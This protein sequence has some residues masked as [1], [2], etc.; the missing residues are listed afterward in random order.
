MDLKHQK[1]ELNENMSED[2]LIRNLKAIS[3][4]LQTTPQ[5]EETQEYIPLSMQ[6][7]E[8]YFLSHP[9]RDVQLLVACCIADIMRIYA[10][11]APYKDQDLI[12]TIFMFLIN[13]LDGISNPRHKSFSRYFYL[14]EILA[15]TKSFT[16]CFE[17]EDNQEVFI[18]LFK[19]IFKICSINEPNAKVKSFMLDI[20]SPLVCEADNISNELLD[21]IFKHIIEPEKS[22]N[23]NAYELCKQLISKTSEAL[24]IY[25]KNFLSSELVQSS[26]ESRAYE[27]T[28]TT[29]KIFEVIHELYKIAPKS[30][31]LVLPTLE[32]K[33]QS[34]EETSRMRALE[35][36]I[37]IL[38]EEFVVEFPMLWQQFKQRF[39]D[40]APSIRR[41]CVAASKIFLNDETKYRDEIIEQLSTRKRDS[42][43]MVRFE[44]VA[45][46]VD[47]ARK[48]W[49]LVVETSLF[50]VLKERVMDMKFFV[51]KEALQGFSIIY[52]AFVTEAV[53]SDSNLRDDENI[54]AMMTTIKNKILHGYY[55]KTIEDKMLIERLLI[56][57]LVPYNLE[58]NIRMRVL[59]ELLCD[60]D[61]H[62]MKAFIELQ[63]QQ[64]KLRMIVS[65]W[66]KCHKKIE[67]NKNE[68]TTRAYAIASQL[69]DQNKSKEQLIKLSG[70]MQKD[71]EVLQHIEAILSKD[72]SCKKC[73]QKMQ[74]LLKKMGN[75]VATNIYYNTIKNMLNRIASVTVDDESIE[76]LLEIIENK[77][78]GKEIFPLTIL[79]Q[80][81]ATHF[82]N[83]NVLN[84][85]LAL[86][87][88]DTNEIGYKE[89][90][91]KAFTNLSLHKSI[92]DTFPQLS[93]E[94][95]EICRQIATKGTPKQC[96]QAVT[97]MCTNTQNKFDSSEFEI[98]KEIVNSF[99][100]SINI[101]NEYCRTAIVAM[102]VICEVN[103]EYFKKEI[104]KVIGRNI[105][106]GL[107]LNA[108][109][110]QSIVNNSNSPISWIE[111]ELLPENIKC[112][113]AA[114]KLTVHWLIGLKDDIVSAQKTMKIMD[115]LIVTNGNIQEKIVPNKYESSWIKLTAAKSILKLSEHKVLRQSVSA[116]QFLNLSKVMLDES[117]QL[118]GHFVKRLYKGLNKGSNENCLP[119][120]FLGLYVFEG[121]ESD[122]HLLDLT[123]RNFN[124]IINI[125]SKLLKVN[126]KDN[127]N[128][129]NME[130]NYLPIYAIALLTHSSILNESDDLLE[131]RKIEKCLKFIIDPLIDSLESTNNINCIKQLIHKIK[132]SKNK[133]NPENENI[134]VKMWTIT[135]I[136]EKIM[137]Y[138]S[139]VSKTLSDTNEVNI[140]L[141]E[142]YFVMQSSDFCNDK[143]YLTKEFMDNS[144]NSNFSTNVSR[145][146]S[147]SNSDDDCIKNG[148]TIKKQKSIAV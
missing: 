89:N 132:L 22:Q 134:N 87:K 71:N 1:Y 90:I 48:N 107:L 115:A 142:K 144:F 11:E 130:L 36:L 26:Y 17:L 112:V 10:P 72:I 49:K 40:I 47:A 14:M 33:L 84:R 136:A 106:R 30:V 123:R 46:V 25:V 137:K 105:V 29:G 18:A 127:G 81:F 77:T 69:P 94:L 63:R 59:Y 35:L 92:S 41:K 13:Q 38:S 79:S 2:E 74:M 37:K 104:A 101:S 122:L 128:T 75:P 54:V 24:S 51:R 146:R 102:S 124:N 34:K 80:V 4:N 65:E 53:Q 16:L 103:G 44:V 100:N 114:C 68:I 91:L 32:G 23:P 19:L 7:A 129:L 31:K 121:I 8:D 140:D 39:A 111:K 109:F 64:T 5:E 83:E 116:H 85:M 98:L 125:K 28:S 143:I 55:M 56:T 147:F 45:A 82:N 113:I 60:I 6:L 97:F 50:E 141:P 108:T 57:C 110:D 15:Y 93:K 66:I 70:H 145:K 3:E 86:L 88:K 73:T 42:D 138:S 118:R 148:D 120:E 21:V 126:D 61:E 95:M 9:S 119:F 52:K 67:P 96:K 43:E 20:T 76:D 139:P 133:L 131:L 27:S 117:P 78:T 99:E 12:K 62:A 135:E 58:S